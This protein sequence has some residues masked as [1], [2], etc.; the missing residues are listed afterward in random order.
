MDTVQLKALV[1]T[2]LHCV[3]LSSL[4]KAQKNPKCRFW[5]LSHFYRGFCHLKAKSRVPQDDR[6]GSLLALV[7]TSWTCAFLGSG[8]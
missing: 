8:S 2:S 7:N 1:L 5:I 6:K 4:F 3:S